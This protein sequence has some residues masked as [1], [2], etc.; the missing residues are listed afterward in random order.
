[1]AFGLQ[2]Q[3]ITNVD[4]IT[5]DDKML[6][7]YDLYGKKSETYTVALLFK[8]T[9]GNEIRPKSV[10]GDI[11]KK[12]TPGTGKTI[13]WEVYKDVDKLQG[14]IEPILKAS[15]TQPEK[16][17]KQSNGQK[18]V[19]ILAKKKDRNKTLIWGWKIGTGKTSVL[20]NQN[21]NSYEKLN[22]FTFGTY[23]RW[24]IRRNIYLQPELLYTR[25]AFQQELNTVDIR[26]FKNHYG[27]A[28]V[29]VGISPFKKGG[30]YLNGGMYYGQLFKGTAIQ[31]IG[32]NT[33]T[34]DALNVGDGAW[35]DTQDYG[36]VAGGTLSFSRGRFGISVLYSEGLPQINNNVSEVFGNTNL[37]NKNVT[38][39][40]QIGF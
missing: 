25:Q 38:V 9:T 19:N 29:L 22:G 35:F 15:P 20:V 6:I 30:I 12:I 7:T 28:Q 5:S 13:V 39:A 16:D 23:L 4:L 2:A 24:N 18:A 32:N 36:W 26:D 21:Q 33:D 27:K 11:G 1:M 37:R 8:T 10:S 17:K 34:I 3:D 14:N 40:A 31:T